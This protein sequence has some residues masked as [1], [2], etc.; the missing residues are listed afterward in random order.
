[1]PSGGGKENSRF[2]PFLDPNFSLFGAVLTFLCEGLAAALALQLAR[3]QLLGGSYLFAS[4]PGW[5][6]LPWGLLLSSSSRQ[7]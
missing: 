6:T 3:K 7:R 2:H 5:Q 1:M 4:F